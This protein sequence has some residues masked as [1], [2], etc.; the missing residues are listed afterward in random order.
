MNS[1]KR[2]EEMDAQ[3]AQPG[4]PM[5]EDVTAEAPHGN[6]GTDLGNGAVPAYR[7]TNARYWEYR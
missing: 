2:A 7:Y 5:Y 6:T 3:P 1:E 4:K